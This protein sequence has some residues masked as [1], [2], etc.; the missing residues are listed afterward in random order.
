MLPC[1]QH[2]TGSQD[3]LAFGSIDL[4]CFVRFASWLQAC[5]S[6]S[7]QCNQ[8]ALPQTSKY[9]MFADVLVLIGL[10]EWP[11]ASSVLICWI[12]IL[13]GDRGLGSS[14]A[15]LRITSLDLLGLIAA[16]LCSQH[17]S[18]TADRGLL[19]SLLQ[20]AGTCLEC[21]S[22]MQCMWCLL[23][24]LGHAFVCPD[25][26]PDCSMPA[27]VTL[28]NPTAFSACSGLCHA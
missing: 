4:A 15:S 24:P 11:A 20:H 14:D 7:D 9:C 12:R 2:Y 3:Q 1:L 26:S 18:C 17:L 16:T 22:L 19:M 5:M 27:I 13:I 25:G 6:N 8:E 23:D 28:R 10:P 21:Q